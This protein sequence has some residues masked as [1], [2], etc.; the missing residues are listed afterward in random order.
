MNIFGDPETLAKMNQ[1]FLRGMGFGTMMDGALNS[2]GLDGKDVPA[3]LIAL[4][5]RFGFKPNADQ[6]TV[7]PTAQPTVDAQAKDSGQAEPKPGGKAA[8]AGDD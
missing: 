8:P 4:L 1:Q 5:E 6:P 7:Q 3:T 2:L